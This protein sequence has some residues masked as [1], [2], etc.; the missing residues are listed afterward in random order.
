MGK[1]F[2]WKAHVALLM[3]ALI[4]GANYYIAKNALAKELI[5]PN[6]FIM[7]R[8][9]GGAV[10]FTGF[11]TL[12]VREKIDRRDLP[13]LA[14][15]ALTGVAI[16]QL[17]FF[18]GLKLTSTIHSSLIMTVTPILVLIFSGLLIKEKTS[19]Q[20]I[21]GIVLGF[22]GAVWLIIRSAGG[23][24]GSQATLTGDLFIFINASS[25][26]IYLVLVRKM[27]SK[28]NVLTV[29]K[30]I[31]LIGIIMVIPFGLSDA[32]DAR[33]AEFDVSTWAAVV[34]V[35]LCTTFLTYL[36][37]AYALSRVM[38]ST[39]SIYIYLQ[40]LIAG[41]LGVLFLNEVLQ[42]PVIVAGSLIFVGVYLVSKK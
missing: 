14:L 27:I 23:F 39:V 11:H 26:G 36:F 35:L 10:L 34:Y 16:N 41:L 3:V 6:G 13:Y 32:I 30:W 8:V 29:T 38:P 22:A 19:I 9:I 7:L 31:F 5:T 24:S 4:Y 20:K 37:N 15:C 40:P 33:Y 28:Y 18:Q 17:C 2:M 21:G 25:Y 42:W 12:F 1:I